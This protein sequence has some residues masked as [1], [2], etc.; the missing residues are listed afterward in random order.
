MMGVP[1]IDF[2]PGVR[3]FDEALFKYYH[4]RADEVNSLDF[5]YLIKF[6]R[7]FVHANAMLANAKSTIQWTPGDKFES[8][9]K[10]LYRK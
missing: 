5:N 3:A 1:A 2:A 8:A 7:A 9:G 10:Q 6:F 4:Q